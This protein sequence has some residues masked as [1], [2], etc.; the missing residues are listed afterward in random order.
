M[1]ISVVIPA[2]NAA[3]FIAATIASAR[4]QTLAPHEL[5]V[6]DDGSTDDTA[7]VAAR[8]GATVLKQA[9]AGV[10]AARNAGIMAAR[11]EWI[12]L[13]DHDDTWLPTKLERQ[14]AA[15]ALQR[16][17]ACVTTDFFREFDGVRRAV[18]CF[19]TEGYSFDAFTTVEV[20][21]TVLLLPHAGEELVTTGFFMFPSAVLVRR[22]VMIEAGMFRVEQRLCEDV[23]CF[24]RVLRHTAMLVVREP[25]WTWHHHR[26]NNSNDTTGIAEGWLRLGDFIEHEPDRYPEGMRKQ[27]RP[28]LRERRRQLVT[29]Y[30]AAG[31]F[32]SARRV[33]RS[34]PV[35]ELRPM[36]AMLAA[37]VALPAPVWNTLRGARRVA[38]ALFGGGR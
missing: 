3:A 27:I 20:A 18:S 23:D 6:V 2:Y 17:V 4:A 37:I 16:D 34:A 33:L 13:L 9:N 5:I 11:G 22:D 7:L 10:C 19:A 12:A 32:D 26:D 36:D 38:R 35:A 8:C 1:R 29:T 21:P 15:L 24:L 28:V 25:L 30:A 31:D 14:V